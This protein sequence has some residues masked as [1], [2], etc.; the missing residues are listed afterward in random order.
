MKF[1]EFDLLGRRFFYFGCEDRILNAE[2]SHQCYKQNESLNLI[3]LNHARTIY[4]VGQKFLRVSRVKF[5]PVE[6]QG[7]DFDSRFSLRQ[8]DRSL[9][10]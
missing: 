4:D 8:S 10:V 3:V 9:F 5:P 6:R 2:Q 1:K 7:P